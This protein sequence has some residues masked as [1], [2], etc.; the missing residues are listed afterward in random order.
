M[1]AAPSSARPGL[2]RRTQ[3]VLRELGPAAPLLVVAFAG[4]LLGVVVLAATEAAWLPLFGAGLASAIA[5]C[6]C[7][8]V[9]AAACLL[10]THAT[11]LVGGFLFGG[12][13]GGALAWLVVLLAAML[14]YALFRPLVGARALAALERAPRA[15]L[16]QRALLGR[17]VLRTAWLIAL[18]RLSPLMPFAATNLLL[19]ALHVRALPFACGTMLGVT[20]RVLAVAWVGAEL[21]AFDLAAERASGN[22]VTTGLA[23]AATLLAVVVVGRIAR[24]ALRREVAAS[25][26]RA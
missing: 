22:A 13:A 25:A 7:G 23:I 21:S 16:V 9:A 12:A 11:S 17:G 1:P 26:E 15:L 4:P 5:F 6:V 24:G 8:A 19:A 20:P 18:L 10:P 3:R 2:V 14:G